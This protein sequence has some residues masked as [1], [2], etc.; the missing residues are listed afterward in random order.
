MRERRIATNASGNVHTGAGGAMHG[1]SSLRVAFKI[2]FGQT[3]W[4]TLHK[5]ADRWPCDRCRPELS[6]WMQ[7]L[8]D[9]VN[10]RLGKS[11]F[12]PEAYGRFASGAL[13]GGYHG[14]CIACRV[15][16]IGARVLAQSPPPRTNRNL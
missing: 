12:R 15:A 1:A 7:G 9:A 8:H 16:R 10:V 6:A 5:M 11:P 4:M 14:T 3:L 2:R 13:E